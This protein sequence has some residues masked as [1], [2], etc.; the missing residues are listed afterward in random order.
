MLDNWRQNRAVPLK[1]KWLA[2]SMMSLSWLLLVVLGAHWLVLTV[3]GGSMMAVACY[4]V[5]RPTAS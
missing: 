2:C 1:A 4:L 5:S 3:A